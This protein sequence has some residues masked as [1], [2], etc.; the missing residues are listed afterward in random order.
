MHAIISI[1]GMLHS[2]PKTLN[3]EYEDLSYASSIIIPEVTVTGEEAIILYG[4]NGTSHRYVMDPPA[5]LNVWLCS[6]CC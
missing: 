1:F 5:D 6:A 3:I 4:G 2:L